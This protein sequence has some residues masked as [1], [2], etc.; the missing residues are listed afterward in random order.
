M[1]HVTAA[2][3]AVTLLAACGKRDEAKT[4][5]NAP[6]ASTAAPTSGPPMA[7]AALQVAPTQ[8][9]TASGMLS[10]TAEADGVRISGQ[11]NGLPKGAEVGFHIHE[12]GDCSAPDASSAGDHFNPTNAQH[13]NPESGAHHAGDMLN[14]KSDDTGMA[15]VDVEATGV[16]LGGGQPNDVLGRAVVVHEKPDDYTT[17]PSGNSGPRIA[18]GVI[19]G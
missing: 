16:T 3:L 18:C 2:L 10:V 19:T 5:A 1:K 15:Q 8:G 4:D 17:Q 14:A 11:L 13:G 12:K 7:S 6:V 9:N